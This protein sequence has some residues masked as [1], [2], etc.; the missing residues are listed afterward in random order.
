MVL[1]HCNG[2]QAAVHTPSK[3]KLPGHERFHFSALA[4]D[5]AVVPCFFFAFRLMPESNPFAA[6]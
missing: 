5:L 2:Q 4:L 1:T 3:F 6:T